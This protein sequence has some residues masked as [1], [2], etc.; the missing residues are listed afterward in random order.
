[1]VRLSK[2]SLS[3]KKGDLLM[4]F[5][6]CLAL[7][8]ISMVLFLIQRKPATS[9][10]VLFFKTATSSF[11]ILTFIS[12]FYENRESCSL[13]LALLFIAGAVC[14]LLGDIWLDEKY[15][16]PTEKSGLLKAGFI[17]FLIG[18]IFYSSAL[19]F[20]YGISMVT[21]ICCAIG[22][23]VGPVSCFVNEKTMGVNFGRVRLLSYVYTTFLTFT[24]GLVTG[25]CIE[26]GFDTASLLRLIG[27]VLFLASDAV[28]AQIY[29]VEN[30]NTRINVVV[31]HALY[32]CA[33]F[34]I[35]SSLFFS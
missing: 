27:M 17:S 2:H 6:I 32:Y 13:E 8:I 5:Y 29:F 19:I 10:R 30:K 11:M 18:H 12:A 34:A 15:I 20:T 14:G 7:G 1:M 9:L 4:L 21:V 3:D 22:V 28:L 31:N 33:Q 35:A 25:L 23:I 16:F 26:G 24:T